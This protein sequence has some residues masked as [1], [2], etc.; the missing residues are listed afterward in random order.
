MTHMIYIYEKDDKGDND[1]WY[2]KDYNDD[3]DDQRGEH[4]TC[5]KEDRDVIEMAKSKMA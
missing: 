1:D 3:K 5:N 2:D 4:D